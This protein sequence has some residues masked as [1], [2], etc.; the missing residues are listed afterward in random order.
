MPKVSIIIPVYRVENY[1]P[2]CLD[3]IDKQT[4]R[5][6]ELILVDDGSPD[7][8]GEMCEEYAKTRPNTKVI[9]QANAGLSA[10][11]NEGVKVA[12]GD[13]IAFVDSDDYVSPDYIEYLVYLA[14]KHNVEVAIAERVL[15]WDGAEPVIPQKAETDRKLSP[16]EALTQICY[17]KISICAWGKLYKRHLVEKYPYP[18]GQLYEDIDTTHK[19]IGATDSVAYGTRPIYFWRQREESITHAVI[20]ERHLY[21]ITATK[22][23]LE[24]ILAHYPEA[25]NAARA[26]CAMKI[27]D[28]AHRLV[29]GKTDKE[30]FRRVRDEIKPIIRPLFKDKRAGL[31]LKVRSLA[32]SMGYVPC[33]AVSKLYSLVKH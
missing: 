4:Y 17:N 20:T 2:E 23:Q 19:I 12:T 13:Y 1:L 11:R 28:L 15:F 32:L 9:H 16:V 7:S 3:S 25:A 27:I 6:F 24:Y 14:E 26:R 22:N 29:L 31:S 30:L 33:L 21:G 5:D 10:A 8:C 18:A